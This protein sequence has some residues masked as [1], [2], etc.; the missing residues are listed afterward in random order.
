MSCPYA[1][2]RKTYTPPA[3]GRDALSSAK[4]RAPHIAVNPPT[5]HMPR[6]QAGEG[7]DAAISE[8]VRKMP[9]PIVEPMAIIVK[10]KSVSERL[11]EDKEYYMN[12]GMMEWWINGAPNLFQFEYDLLPGFYQVPSAAVGT[13][14]GTSP[15]SGPPGYAVRTGRSGGSGGE[16]THYLFLLAGM[17]ALKVLSG[18]RGCVVLD[19]LEGHP[20]LQFPLTSRQTTHCFCE[21][22]NVKFCVSKSIERQL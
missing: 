2:D 7:S 3:C 22:S 5:I 15:P 16:G 20:L 11:R 6:I 10:S 9:E 12:S 4:V 17:P 14:L 18:R 21:L 1:S 13:R 8:G 19:K